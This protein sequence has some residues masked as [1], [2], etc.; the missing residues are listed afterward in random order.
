MQQEVEF[1]LGCSC[2]AVKRLCLETPLFLA[3]SSKCL[4][5]GGLRITVVGD[6]S[7]FMAERSDCFLAQ[8]SFVVF[9][10]LNTS[11]HGTSHVQA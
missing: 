11:V 8:V 4:G 3:Y 5:S 6:V 9:A 7:S 2:A 1:S 10:Q